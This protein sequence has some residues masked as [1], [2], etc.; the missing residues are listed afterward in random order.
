MSESS[1]TAHTGITED[2]SW[3][4][5]LLQS[6]WDM[7]QCHPLHHSIYCRQSPRYNRKYGANKLETDLHS[8]MFAFWILSQEVHEYQPPTFNRGLQSA[9]Q[10]INSNLHSS[11]TMSFCSFFVKKKKAYAMHIFYSQVH[12]C[13]RMKIENWKLLWQILSLIFPIFFGKL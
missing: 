2:Q 11:S 4:V 12:Y 8:H 7:A 9:A 5:P 13:I 1:V 3:Q 6:L 10:I